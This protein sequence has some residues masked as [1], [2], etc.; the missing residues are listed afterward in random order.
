MENCIFCKIAKGEI[1]SYKVYEDDNLIAFLD[2]NPFTKGH[3][4]L[5]PKK[6]IK[7]VWDLDEKDY[8]DLMSVVKRI[9]KVLGKKFN[10]EWVV[11][12]IAGIDVPHAHVHIIPRQIGDGLGAF[13][14]KVLDP[15]PSDKEMKKIADGIRKEII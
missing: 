12:G 4:L 8:L 2:I 1:P 10:T 6:H 3:T 14:N 15:K 9:A 5:V 11:E 13:P 7:W